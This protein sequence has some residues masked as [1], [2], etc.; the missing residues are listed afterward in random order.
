[1]PTLFRFLVL[2]AVPALLTTA[3]AGAAQLTALETR[4]LAA[5]TPVLTYAKTLRLPIDIIVQPKAGPN[6]VPLAMGFA[7]GRCKLVLSMR[8][9][10][11]AETILDDVADERRDVLIE[12]MAAHE[13][14]HCWR[15]A[16]GRWHALPAGFTEVGQEVA[17]N[18]ALLEMSK[19]MRETRRE[20]GFSDLVA[21]AWTQQRHPEQYA[22]VYGWMRKVRDDQPTAH[23]SHDTRA[24]LQLAPHGGVFA[25]GA[26]PFEQASA[27]W[28]KGLLVPE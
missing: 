18:P 14:G 6:D 4:W 5:A 2:A 17:D 20:E 8:G 21:L 27:L 24:W 9:N 23:G 19:Q 26:G 22:H 7:D 28:S 11:H 10:P 16:Q 25:A 15:Y 3:T 13:V 12:A 1:M